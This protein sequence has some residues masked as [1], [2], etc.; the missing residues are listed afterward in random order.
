MPAARR[1]TVS[2]YSRLPG[3][4]GAASVLLKPSDAAESAGETGRF[5]D[6]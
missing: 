5:G 6:F 2:P 4:T 1:T 3:G